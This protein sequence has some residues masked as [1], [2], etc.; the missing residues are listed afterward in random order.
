MAYFTPTFSSPTISGIS[1]SAC[2]I[3]GAKSACVNGNSVG[4]SAACFTEGR[5]SGL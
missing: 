4:D 2:S 5:S 1:S 3:C